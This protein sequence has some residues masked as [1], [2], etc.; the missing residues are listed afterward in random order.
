MGQSNMYQNDGGQID[1]NAVLV[2]PLKKMQQM[3]SQSWYIRDTTVIQSQ[4][5]DVKTPAGL[6]TVSQTHGSNLVRNLMN[7]NLNNVSIYK[8]IKN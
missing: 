1:K 5:H 2:F 6:R 8:Y 3:T 4:T 7:K